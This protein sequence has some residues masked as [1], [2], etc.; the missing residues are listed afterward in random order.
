MASWPLDLGFSS[1]KLST[2]SGSIDLKGSEREVESVTAK[3]AMVDEGG[4]GLGFGGGRG[5]SYHD[6]R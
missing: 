4:V 6:I 2:T 3:D 1:L 5:W